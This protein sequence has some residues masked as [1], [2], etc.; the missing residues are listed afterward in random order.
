[1]NMMWH[2]VNSAP[3]RLGY[4][5][6]YYELWLYTHGLNAL[7]RPAMHF[8]YFAGILRMLL[9]NTPWNTKHSL[10]TFRISCEFRVLL[11]L[12]KNKPRNPLICHSNANPG[13]KCCKIRE[14][15]KGVWNVKKV[16]WNTPLHIFH[17]SRFS[18]VFT[19]E[20]TSCE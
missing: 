20:F 7:I 6:M 11:M 18:K 8:S 3:Y 13:A 14:V 12:L 2:A 9:Q 16:S 15:K 19:S 1:M 4:H 17:F 10:Y 5:P